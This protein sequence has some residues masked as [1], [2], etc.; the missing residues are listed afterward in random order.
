MVKEDSLEKAIMLGKA[1]GS[2]KRGSLNMRWTDSVTETTALHLQEMSRAV[3]GQD[4]LEATNSNRDMVALWVKPQIPLCCKVG[5]T[6]VVR[7]NPRDG[8]SSRHLSQL[9][10]NLAVQKHIKNVSR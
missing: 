8:V 9:L 3:N 1:E 5:R 2:R 7:S 10:A 6:A 4:H